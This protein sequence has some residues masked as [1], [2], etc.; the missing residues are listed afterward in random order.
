MDL[1]SQI[2]EAINAWLAGVASAVLG[3][4]LNALGQLIFQTPRFDQLPEIEAAWQV[5]R[6]TTDALFVL[7][8]LAVGVMVMVSGTLESRYTAKVLVPRL[9]FAAVAANTSLALCGGAIQLG[10]GLVQGLLG[11][12]PGSTVLTQMASMITSGGVADH[13]VGLVLLVIAAA[14]ALMLVALYVGRDLVLL[15]ATVLAPLAIALYA[16]PQTEEIARLWARVYAAL[17]FVQAIQALLVEIGAELLRHTDW[18]GGAVS[19]LTTGLVLLTLL[20]L[21]L[22][23]PFA[24]YQWAFH[25]PL[26]AA[27]GIGK[28][29][30]A[31]RTARL[32]V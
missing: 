25:Q 27:P 32:A 22:K 9:A 6:T 10:N 28:L 11:T 20:F 5:V 31:A 14:L 1:T 4:A 16:L 23:L 18:L 19:D 7:A 21:M 24:A 2:A 8:L 26:R 30:L 13:I 12:E 3:P 17:P 15:V 29:V